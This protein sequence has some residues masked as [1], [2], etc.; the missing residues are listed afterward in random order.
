MTEDDKTKNDED[1]NDDGKLEEWMYD[2]A[3]KMRDSTQEGINTIETKAMNIINFSSILITILTGVL[4]YIKD[5]HIDATIQLNA[6]TFIIWSI[7][8]F[9]GAIISGFLTIFIRKYGIINLHEHFKAVSEHIKENVNEGNN[10]AKTAKGKTAKNIAY[11]QS[12]SLKN[13]EIKAR[14]Y[15]ISCICVVFALIFLL[16]SSLIISLYI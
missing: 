1:T 9:I 3:L 5:K 2:F 11:L 4:Y 15:M 13:G 6:S 14:C 16:L 8:L 7:V 12:K 10:Y